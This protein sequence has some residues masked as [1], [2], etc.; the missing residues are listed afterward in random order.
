VNKHFHLASIFQTR[1]AVSEV[2]YGCPNNL[3]PHIL[4]L[5]CWT[6]TWHEYSK[7]Q[8]CLFSCV[9]CRT[10]KMYVCV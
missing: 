6:Y 4:C 9:C 1:N 7:E 2:L 8:E 10:S 3:V 5:S